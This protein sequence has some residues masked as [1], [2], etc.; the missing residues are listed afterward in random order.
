[1]KYLL[2]YYDKDKIKMFVDIIEFIE[3][4]E[5]LELRVPLNLPSDIIIKGETCG[6]L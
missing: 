5:F 6:T 3:F 4:V 1:M 2:Q